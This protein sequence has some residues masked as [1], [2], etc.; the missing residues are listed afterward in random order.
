MININGY[1]YNRIMQLETAV[2]VNVDVAKLVNAPDLESGISQCVGSNPIIGTKTIRTAIFSNL[3]I[4][5]M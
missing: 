2:G 5:L 4:K 3:G 1:V